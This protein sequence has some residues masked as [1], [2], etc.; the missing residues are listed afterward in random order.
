MYKKDISSEILVS[1][2]IRNTKEE[3]PLNILLIS[4]MTNQAGNR[5]TQSNSEKLTIAQLLL[6]P[7]IH[8]HLNNGLFFSFKIHISLKLLH[9]FPTQGLCVV[10]IMHIHYRRLLTVSYIPSNFIY[11]HVTRTE[12][13]RGVK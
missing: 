12:I 7:Y 13:F 6:N 11:L 2:C 1:Q 9:I 3:I 4:L 5:M 10:I 8:C